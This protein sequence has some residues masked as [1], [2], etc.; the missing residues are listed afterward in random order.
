M[1]NRAIEDLTDEELLSGIARYRRKIQNL[2]N[3][4]F[5]QHTTHKAEIKVYAGKIERAQRVLD[6]R[7]PTQRSFL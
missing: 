7:K 5:A 4:G 2:R 6:A 3:K 1:S